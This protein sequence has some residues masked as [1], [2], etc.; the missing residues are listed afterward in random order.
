MHSKEKAELVQKVL[1]ASGKINMLSLKIVN[2]VYFSEEKAMVHELA[3]KMNVSA[4]AISRCVDLLEKRGLLKRQRD[5][6]DDRRRVFI[7]MGTK[8]NIF[9]ERIMND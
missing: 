6:K 9:M 3:E 7:V 4:P 5:E 8:G 1:L 2:H